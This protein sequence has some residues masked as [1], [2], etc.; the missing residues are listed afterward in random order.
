MTKRSWWL[1]F[2]MMTATGVN[3]AG[4]PEAAKEPNRLGKEA[5]P[6]LRLHAGNPVRWFPWGPD[7]FAEAKRT[8]KPI[9]L[10]IGYS[11]C[12]WCH[13]MNRESFANPKIAEI[14]NQNFICIKVD[15]EERPDVDHVYMQAVQA[16]TDNGGWPL[17]V[18][19]LPDGRPFLGGTYFPPEDRVSPEG[20]VLMSGF[21]RVLAAVLELLDKRRPDV[22]RQAS[23][24]ADYLKRIATSPNVA[25]DALNQEIIPEAIQSIAQNMDPTFGGLAD[26]PRFAPKFPQPTSALFLLECRLRGDEKTTLETVDRQAVRMADGGIYDQIGGGFH[27][28]SVD[29]EWLVPHFEKM[30][31]DQ[32][33][34]LS[35]YSRLQQ[36]RP[37]PR[38]ER[39]VHETISFAVRDLASPEGLFHA[40]IDADSEHEEGKFYVWSQAEI[41][42]H[43]GESAD[44]FI[45]AAGAEGPPNFEGRYILT[46]KTFREHP[47]PDE[48]KRW[49]DARAK[50]LLARNLRTRP[51]LDTKAITTWNALFVLGVCDAARVSRRDD[52][53]TLAIRTIDQMLALLKRPDGTL[54]RYRL[55]Q[56]SRGNGFADDYASMVLAL[57]A[58][59]QLEPR[60]RY[61]DEAKHFMTILLDGYWDSIG[62]GFFYSGKGQ[63]ALISPYKETYDGAV[64]SS[65]SLACLALV[66]LAERTGDGQYLSFAKEMFEAFEP[67][68]SGRASGCTTLLR[69]Y[70]RYLD[71]STRPIEQPIP[72]EPKAVV[73]L[74]SHKPDVISLSIEEKQTVEIQGRVSEGWHVNANPPKPSYLK[75]IRLRLLENPNVALVEVQYPKGEWLKVG[76]LDEEVSVNS[77]DFTLRAVVTANAEAKGTLVFR[78]DYQA[79]DDQ[80]CLAPSRIEF[81]IPFHATPKR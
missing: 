56:T 42:A 63:E 79:C 29:R 66:E 74:I 44:W 55:E 52:Y 23:S 69:A 50:L 1:L 53:R 35:M 6:Y 64:P 18:F 10:S 8:G 13:V 62:K 60:D 17:N 71:L 41:R 81:T 36:L 51:L 2:T 47:D 3:L 20:E 72:T 61:L 16:L 54:C 65:N 34:L 14:L 45:L 39:V 21:P 15:R 70:S 43:L 40:A 7:A 32:G 38:N 4:P 67:M 28:Y 31:Y 24:L 78:L 75:P 59:H 73:Q 77:G 27:R 46:R 57:L 22:E 26:P 11:S 48:E 12:H 5:S 58:V 19:L 37:N 33:Q 49:D 80:K 30:L 68:L 9:F 25:R 76:G